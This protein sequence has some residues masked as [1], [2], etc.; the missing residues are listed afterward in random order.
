MKW[1]TSSKEFENFLKFER[2][3]SDNTISSYI[4]DLNKLINYLVNKKISVKPNN[5][6]T[7][8]LRNFLYEQSKKI[9]SRS[10]SRLISSL[11]VFFNFFLSYTETFKPS[12][13][14]FF[15]L[16]AYSSG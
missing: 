6:Q 12:F 5:I 13:P 16:L 1:N 8:D 10:Q 14:N 4:S 3:L 7:A 11:N 9:K 15:N 2:N